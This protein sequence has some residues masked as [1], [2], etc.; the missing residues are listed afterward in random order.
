MSS[1]KGTAVWLCVVPALPLLESTDDRVRVASGH[2][3]GKHEKTLKAQAR[4]ITKHSSRSA[5]VISEE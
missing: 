3:V 2:A 4:V 1:V 5:K